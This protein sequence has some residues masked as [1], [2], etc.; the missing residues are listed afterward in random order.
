MGIMNGK[1]REL[2]RTIIYIVMG[3]Q[4]F[5]AMIWIVCNLGK[6]PAFAESNELLLMSE[7]LQVDEYTGFLYVL[8]I[9][10][11]AA[12]ANRIKIPEYSILYVLQLFV[13]YGAYKYFLERVVIFRQTYGLKLHKRVPLHALFI[14]TVPVILQVHMAVLPY[15]LASS[16]FVIILADVCM[17]W[18]KDY[19]IT[20][21]AVVKIMILWVVA[22]Q[23]CPDYSW[24]VAFAV[25]P[26][27]IRYMMLHRK[28]AG[29]LVLLILV[30]LISIQNLNTTLQTPG[31]MGK[32]QKTWGAAMMTRI[33]WPN[34]GTF[35]LFWKDE[36]KERWDTAQLAY[37]STYPENVIYEFGPVVD[38]MYGYRA[39]NDIYWEMAKK[40]LDLGTKDILKG[41]LT[42]SVAYICPPFTMFVQL[43]GVGISYTGFNYG[44]L[45]DNTPELT[46]W[47]VDISLRGW[48]GILVCCT[49]LEIFLF[50]KR[51]RSE[52]KEWIGAFL[53]SVS[54]LINLWYMM[55]SGHMQDYKKVIIISI[56][57]GMLVIKILED[58]GNKILLNE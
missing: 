39:A 55:V 38:K 18:R 53:C 27:V 7:S 46:K 13:A 1:I 49:L 8:G 50:K 43:H 6:L 17:F 25:V 9:K 4:I 12:L 48:I 21:K 23:I 24:L 22:A 36:I 57:W 34:Y 35:S 29:K 45:K 19:T 40:S 16:F 51:K 41:M 52:K 5:F 3:L 10:G 28:F 56:L 30:T 37:L 33:V 20:T 15:S 32:I 11:A 31:S 42:D 58:S 14:I 2:V 26:S 47:Y 54:I 44:R